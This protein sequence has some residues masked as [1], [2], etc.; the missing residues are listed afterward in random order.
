M[1][2][3]VRRQAWALGALALALCACGETATPRAQLHTPG[4]RTG[5][6][7]PGFPLVNPTPTPTASPSPTPKPEGGPVTHDEERVIRGWSDELRHGH[8]VAASRYFTVPSVVSNAGADASRL[9]SRADVQEFNATMPCGAK[10]VKTRRSAKRFVI[11]TFKL[12][13]RPGGEC[14]T[15]TGGLVEVAFLIRHHRITRWLRGPDPEPAPTPTP[16]LPPPDEA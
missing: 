9:S 6:A 3:V 5:S 1:T 13:E 15:G 11:G 4:A 7:G 16:V 10:L 14:G 2:P 12:T 8:V